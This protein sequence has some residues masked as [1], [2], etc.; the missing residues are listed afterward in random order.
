MALVK[1]DGEILTGKVTKIMKYKGLTPVDVIEAMAGDIIMITGIEGA[2]VGETL[3]SAE[4]PKALPAVK[5][6]EP[7]ISMNFS[8]NTSPLAGK[9]GGVFLASRHVRE[10]LEHEAMVNVGIKV[11]EVD[12]GERF[13]VSGRGNFI[14]RY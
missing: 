5:I 6:D 11:E 3:S 12:N 9:D 2:S 13:K 7:T 4:S 14:L 1:R 10:Y 8:H